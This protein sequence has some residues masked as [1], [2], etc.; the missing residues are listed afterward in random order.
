MIFQ[1]NP[2]KSEL[3]TMQ[4]LGSFTFED[5]LYCWWAALMRWTALKRLNSANGRDFNLQIRS[6]NRFL[7]LSLC[8]IC[9]KKK[10]MALSV[11]CF[12]WGTVSSGR[13]GEWCFRTRLRP[14]APDRHPGGGAAL[15]WAP[16]GAPRLAGP[17]LPWR[18]W[19]PLHKQTF[20]FLVGG[21]VRHS[22]H[23]CRR[24]K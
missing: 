24:R 6:V 20:I 18:P 10:K 5:V 15:P 19:T 21:T 22:L 1:K 13:G 17:V 11:L 16:R 8:G 7:A 23:S 4:M 3:I 14:R 9:D 12:A 2:L